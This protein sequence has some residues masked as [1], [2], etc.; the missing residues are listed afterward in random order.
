M[1]HPERSLLVSVAIGVGIG[2]AAALALML[3]GFTAPILTWALLGLVAGVAVW[4]WRHL[5]PEGVGEAVDEPVP[6]PRPRS[7]G[8]DRGARLLEGRLRGALW[9]NAT[10]ISALHT[11][12]DDIAH[13]RA[14]DGPYP[15]ALSAYLHADPRPLSRA[16]LRLILRELS[17]L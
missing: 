12:I 2:A 14:G 8:A 15:P 3:V 17:D 13:D 1:R 6:A 10:T 9:G 16:Q 5:V 11:T 4:A 7:A